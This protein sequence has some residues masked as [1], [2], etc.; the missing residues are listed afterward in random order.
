MA[1]RAVD[2]SSLSIGLCGCAASDHQTCDTRKESQ[3]FEHDAMSNNDLVPMNHVAVKL[4]TFRVQA[5]GNV[6]SSTTKQV[7]V[8]QE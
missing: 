5:P 3:V 2:V 6:V 8:A 1:W 4:S 7:F